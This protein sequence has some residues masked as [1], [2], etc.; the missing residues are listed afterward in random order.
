MNIHTH[1]TPSWSTSSLG[2]TAETSPRELAELG[3]HL[4]RCRG[5]GSRLSTLQ[6]AA[7]AMTG[8]ASARLVTTL[9]VLACLIG[10][11]FLIL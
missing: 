8:F 5:S 3:Q 4:Q 10:A 1:Q 9:L 11:S 7:Q 2:R 6:S